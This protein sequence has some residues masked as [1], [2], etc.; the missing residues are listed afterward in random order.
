MISVEQKLG[1]FTQYLLGK[2]RDYGKKT[3]DNARLERR[4]LLSDSEEHI[5]A[6]KHS[7]EE[8]GYQLIYRDRNKIIAQGKNA[9]K[10]SYLEVR[11]Q[12]FDDFIE[13][14]IQKSKAF[15]GTETYKNYL[16]NCLT[17]IPAVLGDHKSI[18]LY[19]ADFDKGYLLSEVSKKLPDYTIEYRP[20]DKKYEGGI[21]VRDQEERINGDFTIDNLILENYKQIG[22]RL[23]KTMGEQVKYNGDL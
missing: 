9:A 6:E 13:T 2:Q 19:V 4:K 10:A 1:V 5:K 21:I 8:R 22:I 12:M 17:K 3:I 14:V 11:S 18:I 7:I 23:L 16:S 15:I 20:L